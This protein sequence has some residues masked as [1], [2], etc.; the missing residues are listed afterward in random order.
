MIILN[1]KEKRVCVVEPVDTGTNYRFKIMPNGEPVLVCDIVDE[2]NNKG[3]CYF[4]DVP[5]GNWK[6]LGLLS[7]INPNQAYDLVEK[8]YKG[9]KN[10]QATT[11]IYS[12]AL[13]SFHSLLR[14]HN[15]DTTKNLLII[16]EQ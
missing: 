10:Y 2:N 6:I 16:P 14:S 4:N 3:T 8:V 11:P 1:T 15:L 13:E 5:S 9:Y 12:T 7:E